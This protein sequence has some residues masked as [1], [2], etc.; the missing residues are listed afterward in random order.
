VG[1]AADRSLRLP[2]LTPTLSAPKGGEGDIW[3]LRCVHS[4]AQA[5]R[6]GWRLL[7]VRVAREP[8]RDQ[9]QA[10]EIL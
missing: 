6:E 9:E 1:R 4:L 2:H 5:G 10:I 8:K 7:P 3:A